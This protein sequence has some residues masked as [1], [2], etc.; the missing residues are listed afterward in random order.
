MISVEWDTMLNPSVQIMNIQHSKIAECINTINDEIVDMQHSC[1]HINGLL[2]QFEQLCQ[3]LFMYEE[4]LL[5]E[6]NFPS[7]AEQ[8]HLHDLY[9]KSIEQFKAENYQCHTASFFNGFI[10]LR[11]DFLSNMNKE[12]MILCDMFM[13]NSRGD[14]TVTSH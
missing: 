3:M 9:L 6:V 1:T 4:Q 2:D 12:T 13:N 7:V 5:E 8:K 11:V 14:T 10:K